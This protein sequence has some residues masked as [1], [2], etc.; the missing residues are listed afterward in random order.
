[1]GWRC[2]L[3][4]VPKCVYLARHRVQLSDE[5]FICPNA[6]L[7]EPGH[8]L[9]ARRLEASLDK[10]IEQIERLIVERQHEGARLRSISSRRLNI[11]RRLFL[12]APY[13]LNGQLPYRHHAYTQAFQHCCA[14]PALAHGAEEYMLGANERRVHVARLFCP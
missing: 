13:R 10:E 7:E 4:G 9:A 11:G 5:R 6:A 3:E 8:H 2:G 1:M 12:R 14:I